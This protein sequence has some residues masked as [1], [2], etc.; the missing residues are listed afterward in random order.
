MVQYK[1]FRRERESQNSDC[2]MKVKRAPRKPKVR[3]DGGGEGGGSMV[4][5]EKRKKRKRKKSEKIAFF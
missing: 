3:R 1:K 2:G 5:E 4:V